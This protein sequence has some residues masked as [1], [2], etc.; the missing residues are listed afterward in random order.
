MLCYIDYDREKRETAGPKAP[1]DIAKICRQIGCRRLRLPYFPFRKNGL[2]KRIWMLTIGVWSWLQMMRT[3]NDEDVIIFQHP[4]YPTFGK[5]ITEYMIRRIK[6][7]KNCRFIAVI[8][9]L[10]PL[11]EG[12]EGRP[13]TNIRASNIK[14]YAVLKYF[15]VIICHNEKMKNWMTDHGFDRDSLFTLD[16]FDYLTEARP[17]D[18]KRN[19]VPEVCIAG[20]LSRE[21]S[22]Y[23]YDIIDEK[24][25]RNDGLILD[26]YRLAYSGKDGRPGMVYH[27]AFPPDDLPGILAGDYGL[28]WDGPSIDTCSGNSGNYLRYNTPH[29]TSLYLAAGIP[30][31]VWREAAIADFVLNHHV[32]IAVDSLA[33]LDEKLQSVPL[34][35]YSRMRENALEISRHLREGF[36][37]RRAFKKCFEYLEI[38]CPEI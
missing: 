10:E 3:I 25:H 9:D 4:T 5:R 12:I 30:V 32:G 38:E 16:I 26:I 23:I 22:S 1:D 17:Q 33:G 7:Q 2:Y 13:G 6:K 8:H 15:D 14:G 19:E 36:Y 37:T 24:E 21:K 31:I 20:Y 34:E 27:G 29:K 28:V 11:R 35:E 18:R